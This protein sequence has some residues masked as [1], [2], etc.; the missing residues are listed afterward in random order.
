M[1][2]LLKTKS[3]DTRGIRQPFG[4]QNWRRNS[5]YEA[6]RNAVCVVQLGFVAVGIFKIGNKINNKILKN[7]ILKVNK[8]KPEESFK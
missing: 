1:V 6:C 3:R 8:M 7:N 2:R 4:F 5:L